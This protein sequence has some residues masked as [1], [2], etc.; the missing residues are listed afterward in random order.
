MTPIR[1]I[2]RPLG[3]APAL[4]V[5]SDS[6]ESAAHHGAI[7]FYH[8]LGAVK[9]GNLKEYESLARA[10]FLVAGIDNVGHGERRWPDFD[11]RLSG[12]GTETLFLDAVSESAAEAPAIVDALVADC[13]ADPARLGIGGIS[14]GGYITYAALLAEPRLAVATPILGSPEWR[15]RKEA[16][17]SGQL[18]RFF[19]RAILS[20]NAG[21]DRSVPPLY[22]RRFHERLAFAYAKAPDRQ[23]Y[24]EFAGA[25]HFMPEADWNRLWDNVVAWYAHFLAR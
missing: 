11:A 8:G 23:R 12:P 6:M 1:T 16:S 24:V 10:G 3:P 21:E 20:Q 5:H 22:A 15:A 19:P 4:L 9:E 18:D 2:R 13:G 17:P 25:G 7:L 14:M